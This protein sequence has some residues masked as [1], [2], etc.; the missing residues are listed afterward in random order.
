MKATA[1]L[2]ATTTKGK[3][4]TIGK[5]VIKATAPIPTAIAM[6]KANGY[7]LLRNK[8]LN[9]VATTNTNRLSIAVY[10]PAKAEK[11]SATL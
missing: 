10:V 11:G 5:Y 2:N 1:T 9:S 4:I 8:T 3:N 6:T 7:F